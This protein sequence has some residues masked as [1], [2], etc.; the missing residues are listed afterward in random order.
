M[1]LKRH[2]QSRVKFILY[3]VFLF[4]AQ[5]AVAQNNLHWDYNKPMQVAYLDVLKLRT[6]VAKASIKAELLKNPN[7][8]IAHYLLNYAEC[9]ELFIQEDRK[10]YDSLIGTYNTRIKLLNQLSASSWKEFC[11]AEVKCH[12]AFVKLKFGEETSSAIDLRSAWL[13]LKDLRERSPTF[14]PAMKTAGLLNVLF[15][16]IPS[17]YAWLAKL[18][19]VSGNIPEGLK[20]L[21]AVADGN[22]IYNMEATC[23]L[24]LSE[25]FILGKDPD[26]TRVKTMISRHSGNLLF[27]YID[28]MMYVKSSQGALALEST[29]QFPSGPEY[30]SFPHLHYIKAELWLQKGQT[31]KAREYYQKYLKTFKGKNFLK[32]CHYKMALS[33]LMDGNSAMCQQEKQKV[34]ITGQAVYDTDKQAQRECS[35]PRFPDLRLVRIRFLTDGGYYMEAYALAKN[36]SAQSFADIG[37]KQEFSY[38]MARLYHKSGHTYSAIQYYKAT[39]ASS[40]GLSTYFAPNSCLQLGYMYAEL[41]NP[42]TANYYFKQVFT[43]KN[44]EYKNTIESKARAALQG[45]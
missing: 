24:V 21:K 30:L 27:H 44:Y 43:Y 41:N 1:S 3:P 13:T 15:G 36:L 33:Y 10:A 45:N 26:H 39:I 38:R 16:S 42:T 19:G 12:W 18:S 8:G 28:M 23:W 32:D 40:D 7:N 6:N 4:L 35:K 29:N 5:L 31:V 9:I 20:L 22:T 34:L 2:I 37:D 14:E 17:N 11:I 25:Y